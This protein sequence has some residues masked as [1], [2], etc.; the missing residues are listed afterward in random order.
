[1][2]FI[3]KDTGIGIAEEHMETIFEKF[4]QV[5]DSSTRAFHGAG[6]GLS[7]VKELVGLMNGTITVKS[8]KGSGST[9]RI[10]LPS[11]PVLESPS[12]H[13]P[14]VS[15]P[16]P[17]HLHDANSSRPL[18]LIVD[19]NELINRITTHLLMDTCR[20]DKA[21]NGKM[22]VDMVRDTPYSLIL[23]DMHMPVMD[24]LEAT[25]KIRAMPHR[26]HT[27]IIGLTASCF[28]EDVSRCMTSG[29]DFVLSKPVSKQTL[30]QVVMDAVL[31]QTTTLSVEDEGEHTT[32]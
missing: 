5:D 7:V 15:I 13:P 26:R 6:L 9:F 2:V 30:T 20:C 10:R 1:L 21:F 16:S 19:D 27:P 24:G 31:R 12:P 11:P 17:V 23:M 25:M 28:E 3:V 22:A 29:M 4:T 14:R 32:G 18:I 8:V